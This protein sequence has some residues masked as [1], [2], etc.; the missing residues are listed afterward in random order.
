MKVRALR[1]LDEQELLAALWPD[2]EAFV[3]GQEPVQHLALD[4]PTGDTGRLATDEEEIGP[5][6]WR[7]MREL[8][9]T[10]IRGGPLQQE[11]ERAV[12]TPP[13]MLGPR[14]WMLLPPARSQ[15]ERLQRFYFTIL[16][17]LRFPAL[18]PLLRQCDRC[19]RFSVAT[20]AH[21]RARTFC[22][23]ECRYAFHRA[24]RGRQAHAEKMKEYRRHR[25]ER[26]RRLGK[27]RK[28]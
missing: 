21:R 4:E 10:V 2:L 7:E 23:P 8:L 6:E 9:A 11:L 25:R 3:N 15:R 22:S 19:G 12:A 28:R 27:E 17:L 18:R 16:L 26:K 24:R 5:A 13:V 1:F 20:R 14:G